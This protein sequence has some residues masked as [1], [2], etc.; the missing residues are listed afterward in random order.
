MFEYMREINPESLKRVFSFNL[1]VKPTERV[2][3]F[4]DRL[5]AKEKASLSKKELA[6][7]NSLMDIARAAAK[8]GLEF[9]RE[10]IYMEYPSLGGHAKEPPE[11]IW[12]AAFGGKTTD[13]LLRE[14]ILKDILAKKIGP[15]GIKKAAGIIRKNRKECVNA[16]I[17]LS[18]YSTSHTAF[19][20]F[21]TLETRARY[22]S[23]PLFDAGML[24]GPMRVDYEEMKK[25]SGRI[26]AALRKAIRIE[27]KT[28]NGTSLSFERGRR[29]VEEDTGDL[30]R[31]ASFGNLPAGEVYL[32]PV[33]GTAHG[34]LVLEWAP[35]RKLK[36]PVTL[37]IEKGMVNFIKGNEVFVDELAARFKANPLNAN[38][39]EL[40]IG[41]NDKAKR[42][43]NIL[44]S[45]KILGT[46][47]IALGDNSTF[48]GKTRAPFHQ[49]FIFFNPTLTLI[50]KE[51]E[52]ITLLKKGYLPYDF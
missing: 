39:A 13:L 7:R 31:P 14:R 19:R 24:R 52:K 16:V 29:M 33:E 34:K 23:M 47:H 36:N 44:E 50:T 48:G 1:A 27:L 28:P 22:A 15:E 11:K 30:R 6:R 46:A 43:D 41:T 18:N 38:V 8:T 42:P 45:E 37:I 3:V 51:N 9:A 17:A 26:A 32:A 25:R 21:L 35:T 20:R 40:G 10:V 49:D 12:R 5:T 2:L 4:T